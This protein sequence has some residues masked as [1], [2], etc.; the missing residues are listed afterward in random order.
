MQ[1]YPEEILARVLVPAGGTPR[2]HYELLHLPF[3]KDKKEVVVNLVLVALVP[4]G[5]LLVA[6]PEAAWSTIVAE[7]LLPRAG[8]QKA[9]LVEVDG[10]L[11]SAPEEVEEGETVRLW[12]GMLENKLAKRIQAGAHLQPEADVYRPIDGG[13]FVTPFGPALAEV[14]QDH[15]EFMTASSENGGDGGG[16]TEEGRGEVEERMAKMEATMNSLQDFIQS[17]FAAQAQPLPPR[18]MSPVPETP[19]DSGVRGNQGASAKK[20]AKAPEMK[21]DFGSL[22]P[23]VVA[24]AVKA[25]IPASQ[26]TTLAG[27]LKK[28]S[29]MQDV[30]PQSSKRAK[31]VLSET[32]EEDEEQD[33]EAAEGL[34]QAGADQPVMERALL[35]LTKI[36]GTLAKGKKVAEKKGIEQIL[37]YQEGGDSASSG[38]SSRSKA[39]AY[40]RL[41]AA[42]DFW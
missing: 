10:A 19:R 34:E 21:E 30:P 16:E 13:E 14:A 6:V 36:A 24:E 7:R 31:N 37:E 39:A 20:K 17:H 28:T 5:R 2:A 18:G 23:S 40:Q 27:L 38:S 11:L 15:F 26:L 22:D 29:R 3:I 8:L 9:I 25:G 42:L 41:R 1:K 4:D 32:E 33:A 35:Q 12:V